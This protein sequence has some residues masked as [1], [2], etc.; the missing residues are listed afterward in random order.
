MKKLLLT[1]LIVLTLTEGQQFAYD[2]YTA[3]RES[4]YAQLESE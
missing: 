2:L 3:Y 4:L 1:L